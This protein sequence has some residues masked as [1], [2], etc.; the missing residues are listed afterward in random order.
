MKRLIGRKFEDLEVQSEISRLPF[1][2]VDRVGK[3]VIQVNLDGETKE[4]V[5]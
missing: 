5:G 3:P 4:L 1:A 2:V